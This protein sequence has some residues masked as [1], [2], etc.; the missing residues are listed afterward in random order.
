MDK[1]NIKYYCDRNGLS[2]GRIA[3]RMMC[4]KLMKNFY[5]LIFSPTLE[6]NLFKSLSKFEFMLRFL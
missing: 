2:I 5:L 3:D 6:Q 1:F 4:R